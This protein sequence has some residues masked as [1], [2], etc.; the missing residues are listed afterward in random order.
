MVLAL[1]SNHDL[2]A[3]PRNRMAVATPAQQAVQGVLTRL[4]LFRGEAYLDT[5]AGFP[6]LEEVLVDNPDIKAIETE[7]RETILGAPNVV[8][9]IS[10]DLSLDPESRRLTIEFNALTDFGETGAIQVTP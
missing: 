9:I 1:D 4:R 6:W 8:D 10:L 7:L 5:T 2:H 3:G